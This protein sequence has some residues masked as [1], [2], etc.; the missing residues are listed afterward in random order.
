MLRRE[1]CDSSDDSVWLD[2]EAT[3]SNGDLV[4]LI[5]RP[6]TAQVEPQTEPDGKNDGSG[7]SGAGLVLIRT[8]R[9]DEGYVR[10]AYLLPLESRLK[11][12]AAASKVNYNEKVLVETR[13]DTWAEQVRKKRG[14]NVPLF[15]VEAIVGKRMNSH[16]IGGRRK[17][18]EYLVRWKGYSAA[19]DTWE[20]VHSLTAV[21]GKVR[22]FEKKR[23][24][25]EKQRLEDAKAQ[26]QRERRE[27]RKQ[28]G[29]VSESDTES[30]NDS[31]SGTGTE[32]GGES[33]SGTDSGGPEE[34]T[35]KAA[36][37]CTRCGKPGHNS[38]TC[39]VGLRPQQP[40][41]P[42]PVAEADTR[43]RGVVMRAVIGPEK[44]R[45]V[46]EA[47]KVRAAAAT[48]DTLS[49]EVEEEAASAIA[50][51]AERAQQNPLLEI[52]WVAAGTVTQIQDPPLGQ[53][54][55]GSDKQLVGRLEVCLQKIFGYQFDSLS[56]E[57]F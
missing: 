40:S 16:P 36:R 57:I 8:D 38:R 55:E 42:P 20:P 14:S 51:H 25:E 54:D 15:E 52:L 56:K 19:D 53:Y 28:R 30:H 46:A 26:A 43:Q 9:G 32:S 29:A 24:E 45:L 1:P 49:P 13:K 23:E 18:M 27:A 17:G 33:E 10:S 31:G 48:M 3:V 21:L 6:A 11:R 12:G 39:S 4:Q 50:E 5:G 47:Q 7:E 41:G 2:N 44:D 34:R 35:V 37:A 22:T